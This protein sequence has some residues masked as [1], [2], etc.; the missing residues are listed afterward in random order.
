MRLQDDRLLRALYDGIFEQP[1]W[2][3][4]LDILRDTSQSD[5]VVVSFRSPDDPTLTS[6]YSGEQAGEEVDIIFTSRFANKPMPF[7]EMRE[8]RVYSMAELVDR[9]DPL[10]RAYHDEVLTPWGMTSQYSVRVAEK[11]GTDVWLSCFGRRPLSVSVSARLSTLAPHLRTAMRM[12]MALEQERFRSELSAEAFRKLNFGW[13]TLD[14]ECRII[15]TSPHMERIFERSRALRRGRYNRLVAQRPALDREITAAVKMLALDAA[16]RP[17]AFNLSRDPLMDVLIA[18]LR[19]KALVSQSRPVAIV[20][21]NGDR[22]SQADRCEQLVELFGLLPSEAR[23]AWAIA[24]GLTISEAAEQL[25]LTV[26]T[27]RSYSKKI[28]SKTGARGQAELV[29]NILT[30]VLAMA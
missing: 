22:E 30:S 25:G 24:Q 21:V 29:R 11:G 20:Y 15:D 17:I 13:L 16:A 3:S 12:F 14:A 7:W 18:P 8:D 6:L 5:F 19:T 2:Q 26:E 27:A 10:Q 23:L 1:L 9:A 28:Y 4:F